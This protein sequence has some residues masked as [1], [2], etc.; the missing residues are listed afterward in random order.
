MAADNDLFPY[1]SRGEGGEG[2]KKRGE[3]RRGGDEGGGEERRGRGE[4][5]E[6]RGKGEESDDATTLSQAMQITKEQRGFK[7]TD[8]PPPILDLAFFTKPP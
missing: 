4:G 2:K 7:Q 6:M 3:E 5:D 1:N 8:R